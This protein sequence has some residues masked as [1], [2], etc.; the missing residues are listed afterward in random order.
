MSEGKQG[1]KAARRTLIVR[2]VAIIVLVG[3]ALTGAVSSIAA[4]LISR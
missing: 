2:I 4:M 1:K 3:L